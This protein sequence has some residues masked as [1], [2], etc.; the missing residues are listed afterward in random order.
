MAREGNEGSQMLS[1]EE[2]QALRYYKATI[3]VVLQTFVQIGT[4]LLAIREDRLY[5]R[6][7]DTFEAYCQ[8]RWG[9]SSSRAYQFIDSAHVIRNLSTIVGKVRKTSII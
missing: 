8:Q 5:R 7:Y 3:E 4:A 9:M 2:S 1:P 6:E